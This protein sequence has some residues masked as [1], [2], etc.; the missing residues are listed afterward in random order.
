MFGGPEVLEVRD[1]CG[2]S[3]PA[4]GQL[5]VRVTAAGLNPMDWMFIADN[6]F[7]QRLRG[8]APRS[9]GSR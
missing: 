6:E 9:P 4:Q 7:G 2:T 8:L 5:R 1:I 3:K